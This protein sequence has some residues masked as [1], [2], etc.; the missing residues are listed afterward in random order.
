MRKGTL[1]ITYY[2]GARA[3]HCKTLLSM[4]AKGLVVK[5]REMDSLVDPLEPKL[6]YCWPDIDKVVKTT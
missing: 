4:M 5:L 2:A 1:R 6:L 3:K